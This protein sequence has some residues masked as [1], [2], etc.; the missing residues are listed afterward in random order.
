MMRR[1][2][3]WGL[4]LALPLAACNTPPVDRLDA[5]AGENRTIAPDELVTLSA[6]AT[7]GTAPYIFRWNVTVQ[8]QGAAVD[9]TGNEMGANT[10]AGVLTVTGRYQFRVRVT[11]AV[12]ATDAS[13][14]DVNVGGDI[15]V[16]ASAR[17]A[18]RAVDESTP[19]T[20][21]INSNTSG[22]EDLTVLW[23]VVGGSATLS[24]AGSRNPELTITAE[25]TAKVRV[26]VTGTENEVEKT[27]L[28]VVSVVGVRDAT[29]QVV[30]TNSGAVTGEM[31][32]ELFGNEAPNSVAN[33]LR[34]VD[35]GFY[36]GLVWHR[37]DGDFVIQTGAYERIDG[38][39][40]R[41]AGVRPPIDSEAN[42]GR[43][44]RRGSVG[45]ALRGTDADSGD[46]QFFVDVVDN[47]GLD[48][49]TPPYTVF[50]RVVAGLEEVVD[51]IAEV[52]IGDEG[53]GLT[54][55]P[56]EDI[57]MQSIRRAEV[58]IPT[59]S[60]SNGPLIEIDVTAE[61]DD[62]LRIVGETTRLR[63]IVADP[64]EGLIYNWTVV[65]GAA[66]FDNATAIEPL[67]T[68]QS[69]NTIQFRVTV[70]GEGVRVTSADVFVVGVDSA[71]PR[72]II[73]HSGGVTGDVTLEL[74]TEAAPITC[75]NFLR[76]VD[77][78][79]YDGIL[80]HRVDDGFVIQGGAFERTAAGLVQREGVRPPIPSEANNGE[81][82][83]RATVAMALR[84]SDA[85]SGTNQFFINLGDNSR[86]DNGSP[87][88]T[89]F[90]RVVEGM[91][92]VDDI[93]TVSVGIDEDASLTDVPD[94]DIVMASVRRVSAT[95]GGELA[96]FGTTATLD[97]A[98]RANA[99]ASL[100]KDLRDDDADIENPQAIITGGVTSGAGG[101]QTL[102]TITF[103][104]PQTRTFS[105][106]Y[107]PDGGTPQTFSLAVPRSHH[108]QIVLRNARV[109]I[110]GGE[111]SASG[112][113]FGTPTANVEIF[114]PVAGELSTAASMSTP[115]G[116]GHT[117]TRMPAV[118]IV[119]AG[120]SNWEVYNPTADNWDGPYT[121]TAS[122]LHHASVTLRNINNAGDDP[123]VNPDH[124]A[125]L[126]G[127][128]GAAPTSIE[129]LQP[130]DGTVEVLNSV[131]PK[132]LRN[133]AAVNINENDDNKVLIVGG[134]DLATGNSVAD[135]YILEPETDE[136]RAVDP[137]PERPTG[138]AHHRLILLDG[139]Y[140]VVLAGA[141]VQGGT[142]TALDY[143]AIFDKETE[144]WVEH[145][146]SLFARVN[147]AV[148][149]LDDTTALI[150]GGSNAETP[151]GEFRDSAEVIS[152][153]VP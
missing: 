98:Q 135:A 57:V 54:E 118:R 100:M 86:L 114:D 10:S 71:T 140:A 70:R 31:V 117:A 43:T 120:G 96:S 36:D 30:V 1:H 51:A 37:V 15:S 68:V 76:Y 25:Q 67:A 105:D 134:V 18:L 116:R 60:D 27:G 144:T 87:P 150:V 91:D 8:P 141:Q 41:R 125:L 80:W 148:A 111:T 119:V 89:V 17:D 20:L 152:L 95:P 50:G 142:S 38:D 59:D 149:V 69:A 6:T 49:G 33:F 107:A 72:V 112:S 101:L 14:V 139:R 113:S 65:S 78:R 4:L 109:V 32:I 147:A 128:E 21:T 48:S 82:N 137:L 28:A 23:E 84:G 58:E 63:A 61:S 104:D 56:L 40:V 42:N 92:V 151:P 35:D 130:D 79:F 46:S 124:R 13:F 3:W 94:V 7:G 131:L 75:A 34:Y 22:L 153:D 133:L 45:V 77:D 62:P 2:R 99:A 47:F 74:L 106:E 53:N 52:E 143:Y 146:Q 12:G 5:D 64:P 102:S 11:D 90:A 136:L 138:I 19:L 123:F 73:R 55:V 132:S 29:P 9:L 93:S 26:T 88:F 121:L 108:Q 39:L 145:G 97:L 110:I 122:R 44:N 129:L 127:G 81:S 85:N 16:T 83:I 115:R 126:V 103:F 24:D 66:S